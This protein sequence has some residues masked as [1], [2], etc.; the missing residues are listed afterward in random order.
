MQDAAGFRAAVQAAHANY[1][2]TEAHNR[3]REQE[4]VAKGGEPRTAR[5]LEAVERLIGNAEEGDDGA[6]DR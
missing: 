3:L 1:Q 5:K 4:R 6:E 2:L